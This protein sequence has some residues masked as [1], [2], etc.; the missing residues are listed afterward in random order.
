MRSTRRG[1]PF[2]SRV[3]TDRSGWPG[4][5][6]T[7]SASRFRTAT[8]TTTAEPSFSSLGVDVASESPRTG[9][10]QFLNVEEV[11]AAFKARRA[12]DSRLG[13][14]VWLR[15]LE[16]SELGARLSEEFGSASE[17]W[18]CGV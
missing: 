3:S 6:L 7:G 16:S 9:G 15:A 2:L 12:S 17:S 10:V 14:T 8:T 13:L 4:T 18:L 11:R 1:L 5:S